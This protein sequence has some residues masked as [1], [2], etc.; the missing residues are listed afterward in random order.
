MELS[1]F[2]RVLQEGV[3][4]YLDFRKRHSEVS[5]QKLLL[6]YSGRWP[7]SQWALWMGNE[8]KL[9]DKIPEDWF[10]RGWICP[11]P[12]SAEQ[13]SAFGMARQI[14][15]GPGGLALDVCAGLG[16]DSV[17]MAQ[18]GYVVT[19]LE[20][21][22]ILARAL[23][24]N[25]RV[26][27]V[28]VRAVH[29][30]SEAHW[31]RTSERYDLIY[32]DPD[33]RPGNRKVRSLEDCQPNPVDQIEVWKD[34]GTRVQIKLSPMFDP[35]EA[36]RKLGYTGLEAAE[37]WS[38]NGEVK[39]LMLRYITPAPSHPQRRVMMA[40]LGA[41]L[42]PFESP[43]TVPDRGRTIAEANRPMGSYPFLADPAP[44]LHKM[45]LY[46][47]LGQHYPE[48]VWAGPNTHW[49]LF[50]SPPKNFPGK[51]F[52]LLRP[53]DRKRDRGSALEPLLRNFPE[54]AEALR[55]QHH[56]LP[57]GQNR[58]VG[59]RNAQGQAELWIA[60]PLP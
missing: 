21:N 9:Q 38:W 48:A 40:A 45:Q 33:R 15:W 24:H 56:L 59:F 53:F 58:L 31:E 27:E 28:N 49:M 22:P 41:P 11:L 39:E 30:S 10:E 4:A 8:R 20:T 43:W 2:E 16:V 19:A 14:D 57:G 25:A 47:T 51:V 13:C 18:S 3:G 50:P 34:R 26:L 37:A 1:D 6:K 44:A 42:V 23:E 35:D 54:K 46:G 32:A 60:E 7:A 12:L 17:A 5:P 55:K 36:I 52:R 29:I